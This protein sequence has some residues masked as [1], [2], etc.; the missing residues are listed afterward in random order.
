MSIDFARTVLRGPSGGVHAVSARAHNERPV[1]RPG[2]R[3]LA[4]AG[5]AIVGAM[6]LA[7]GWTAP[8]AAQTE[9]PWYNAWFSPSSMNVGQTTQ[10]GMNIFNNNSSVAMTGL[11]IQG[12]QLPAGLTGSNPVSTCGGTATY[13]AGTRTL[14]LSGASIAAGSMCNL[15]LTVTSSIAGSYSY[16]GGGISAVAGGVTYS[17]GG[18][19]TSTPLQVSGPPVATSFGYGSIVAYNGGGDQA[20]LLDLSFSTS[21]NPTSYAVGSATTAQG[22]SVSVDSAGLATYV[23]PVGFRGATDS[24]TWTA[25]NAL[26]TSSP[27][28]ATITIGNPTL[29]TWVTGSGVRGSALSGVQINVSD[30]K[31]PYTCATSVAAGALPAGVSINSNCTLSGTPTVSGTFNF[32]VN[33]TDSSTGAGPYTAPSSSLT[34]M[35]AAPT[36]SLSP[37]SG[38]LPGATAGAAYSQ[39]FTAGGASAPYSYSLTAGALPSGLTLSGGTLSGVPTAVGTFNFTI[40]ATDSSTAGSGGPYTAAQAYSLTV[41]SPVIAL[42][43]TLANGTV[44]TSY[45]S[46]VAASGGTAPYSYAVTAGSLPTGISLAAN[47]SLSGTPT[48]A[49]TFNFTVTASDATTGPAAPYTG[50]S[51][52]SITIAAPTVTLSPTTL[53]GGAVG[54]AYSTAITASGGTAGY[55]YA[56][57][58]GALPAGLSLSSGGVLTGTPT[59]GGTF[60]FTVTA[61]D[62]STGTGAPFTGSRAY[63][64][65]VAPGVVV[66]AP[67]TL[68]NGRAGAAY[69]QTVTAS[70]GTGPYSFAV[71]AGALP[72]GWTL[73]STGALTGTAT[74]SDAYTF[75]IT[76]TDSSTGTGAPYSGSR[77]FTVNV[78]SPNFTLTPP[79][80]SA[81]VGQAYTGAF[82]AGGGTAP[83]TYTRSAGTLPSGMTLGTDGVLAG[84]PTASGTF[85]FTVI[86]RDSTGGP[87]APYGVGSNYNFT[88]GAP[89]LAL[90]PSA[91]P[92]GSVGAAY[93]STV[94][95]S[96]GTSPYSYA[97]TS[98]ALPPGLTL[99]GTAGA[100]SGTPT[101]T[102]TFNFALTATDASTGAG[103]PFTASQSYAVTIG[104]GTQ[105][106]TFDALTDASLSASPLALSATAD[107]GLAVAFYSDTPAVCTV[108]GVSL[109]LL[110]VGTCTVRAEQA[111]NTSYTAAPP[112]SRSFAVTAAYLT[113]AAGAPTGTTVGTSYSQTHNALGGVAPYSYALAAGAFPPGVTLNATT[114][115]VSGVPTVA[116]AFSYIV[117][118]SDG[119]PTPFTADT[120]VTTVTIGKGSQTL[121]FTST[122]PSAVVSGPAYTVTATSSSGLAPVFTLD[123]A[124]T[125]CALTGAVVTFT[126]SGTCIVNANQ[127]GDANW[128]AAAQVQQSFAVG[129]NPPIAADV[130][131]VNIP[132]GST[133][134]AIDLSA[135]ISGV[136]SSIAVATAPLHGTAG[137][138]GDVITYTPTSGYYGADSFTYTATGPGGT[139]S[140]ATVSLTVAT[141]P[142]PVVEEPAPVVVDP[143]EGDGA[144]SVDLSTVSSGVVTG[145]RVE[146][147]PSGGSVSLLPPAGAA[148]A[149]RLVYTPASN[150]MGED[151]V[152]LVAQGPGG[153]SAPAQFTFRVRGK[154]PDLEGATNGE[155]LTFEPTAGLIGGPF[156]GLV[157]TRQ[158]EIGSAEVV[159]LTIV[160]D[161]AAAA[162][163]ARLRTASASPSAVGPTSIEYAVVLAFGQSQPGVIAIDALDATPELTPLTANT[164]AGRPVTVSLTDTAT[165]GPFTGAA[166]VSVSEGGSATIRE[167]GSPDARTYDL[168][169]TPDGVFTGAA[170][171][172]YT[173]SNAGG[174]TEGR[175]VV[176]V[177]ARPDPSVDP[178]VRG[179]V[180]AQVDT[181]RRFTRAQT[182]NFHRRLEQVRRGGS[183]GVSNGVSL[184]F[185][186]D[187]LTSDPREALRQQ[188]GHR[189]NGP[190]PFADELAFAAAPSSPAP[191]STDAGAP[192]AAGAQGKPGVVGVWTAGS[193]DW[194]RRDAEGQRDYRFTTSGL[195]AGLDMAVADGVVLGG[196]IGYGND[197]TK[198][199]DNATQ[200]EAESY[201]GAVYGSWRVAEGLLLDGVLGYGSLD[202]ESRRWSSDEADFLFG[203]RS[204]SILFGSV[205]FAL[206]RTHR[207]LSWSPYAQLSFGSI[208]LDGFTETGS[209]VFALRYEALETDMLASTLGASFDW[210]LERRDGVLAPSLRIEW[211]HEFEGTQDQIVSY[212][213]WLASPDYVVGLDRW[214]RDSVSVAVGLQWRAASGWTFGADYQGQFSA[215]LA[216]QGLKF[217]L[218]KLF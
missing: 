114:G 20:T 34:L 68:P 24:F 199:G 191:A 163:P 77:S 109:T 174:A 70:G 23:P 67:I 194:G 183:G 140:P 55:A 141:P 135:S 156:Q 206:E 208:D 132:Y 123:A 90:A 7:I 78:F 6:A 18:T 48:A 165:R 168:T 47:G 33:V 107:S 99:D 131:G 180:S 25:T 136:H 72:P 41:G 147:A 160:Y 2:A 146:D 96:G 179:L 27:A 212:A 203:E 197:R 43:P 211:R 92:N 94:A 42:T 192:V 40:S 125:G 56:V 201:L 162:A 8:A 44:G 138:A 45:A 177:D 91:L 86:A 217:R 159:G 213:D 85:N 187:A 1:A 71:T 74:A 39:A 49:G 62:S 65:T 207:N 98:G 190:S 116:G 58:S 101:A 115:V 83:Y 104:L 97:V 22:G 127:P 126:S 60:N 12:A 167:G 112:V 214:A 66:V 186:A 9:A 151:H 59:A 100:I 184:N 15:S 124:S 216:S 181:A 111:G 46:T 89:T 133:G 189:S 80:L 175:L 176:T 102:G 4:R 188:L 205:S 106:I 178:E 57:T 110:Q 157:I 130:P 142:P 31:A 11:A 150:F 95:A 37:A 204:G 172:T 196:G 32:V 128:N 161:P 134:V 3:R 17:R 153:E 139:S 84:T 117:R 154:A 5:W 173:L 122:P 155:T 118:A 63:T 152:T 73:S 79:T 35:V 215:D 143:T 82:V 137:V 105:T 54:A 145:F 26:G 69:S 120:P 16:T 148:T 13:N 185:G 149:W 121:G 169:F 30:G 200:S 28:T 209:E 52:Y 76:A 21:G 210:T 164:L 61:I 103:A 88:V 36:V 51:A 182:S 158:P 193:I 81:T 202:Y 170:V 129:V 166:V 14:S 113:I 64:L 29:M 119:Q 171:V 195:S 19:T 93:S 108:S 75:T 53:T 10:L 87:G 50:S 198:V 144:T 218:M 38:S